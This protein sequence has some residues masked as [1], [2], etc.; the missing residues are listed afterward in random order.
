MR[1]FIE[2]LCEGVSG[3]DILVSLPGGGGEAG[4]DGLTFFLK[5][6]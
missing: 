3:Q 6:A 4:R 1:N 2:S 5:A